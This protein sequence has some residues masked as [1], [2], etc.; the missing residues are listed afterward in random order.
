MFKERVSIEELLL[1]DFSQE[2][3]DLLRRRGQEYRY[4]SD[5]SIIAEASASR[6]PESSVS[7]SPE[8]SLVTGTTEV[9][10]IPLFTADRNDR[11]CLIQ[12]L[13]QNNVSIPEILRLGFSRQEELFLIRTLRQ[14]SKF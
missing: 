2:D 12:L 10:L 9:S 13:I 8:M 5:A 3:I 7:W 4:L 1:L 14:Q 6:P 11:M